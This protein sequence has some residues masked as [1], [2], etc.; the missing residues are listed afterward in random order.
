M[1]ERER[2][3]W[4]HRMHNE[5]EVVRVLESDDTAEARQV[6]ELHGWSEEQVARFRHYARLR[7]SVIDHGHEELRRR[8]ATGAEP[9]ADERRLRFRYEEVEPTVRDAVR[10]LI[11]HGYD[12]VYSGF[13][14]VAGEQGIGIRNVDLTANAD[15]ATVQ[16][17]LERQGITLR[18]EPTHIGFKTERLLTEEEIRETWMTI[19]RALPERPVV[20]PW[21]EP[22]YVEEH[23]ELER[24][25]E[26]LGISLDDLTG[27]YTRGKLETLSD[28]DWNR[29]RNCDS[30]DPSWTLE[31]VLEYYPSRTDQPR[32]A[33][34]ILNGMNEGVSLPAPVVLF[35][36][37]QD[38]YLVSGSTRLSVARATGRRP[39]IFAI[40]L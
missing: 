24:T 29:M 26:A 23:G 4:E 39:Q 30:R 19:V 3:A 32:D 21:K 2:A 9:N 35:R 31:Q 16:E 5:D 18:V 7:R 40:R 12:T 36:D 6:A 38:P 8:E 37:G 11:S 25:S 33:Q 13:I 17:D 28:E 10:W 22:D 27:A 20:R 34:R 1:E 14:G 15:L